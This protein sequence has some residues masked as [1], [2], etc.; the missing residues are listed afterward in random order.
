MDRKEIHRIRPW[1]VDVM[2]DGST[3][4]ARLERGM[5]A[6]PMAMAMAMGRRRGRKKWFAELERSPTVSQNARA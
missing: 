3:V 5:L 2:R 6:S 1:P 4:S